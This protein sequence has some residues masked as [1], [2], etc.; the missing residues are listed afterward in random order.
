MHYQTNP[1][2]SGQ[3]FQYSYYDQGPQSQEIQHCFSGNEKPL[4]HNFFHHSSESVS[5]NFG[6]EPNSKLSYQMLEKNS[7]SKTSHH[8]AN[9]ANKLTNLE[10]IF[11]EE[12]DKNQSFVYL[13]PG[14]TNAQTNSDTNFH[15]KQSPTN[16]NEPTNVDLNATNSN[17]SSS[18]DELD[19]VSSDHFSNP[20]NGQQSE[21]TSKISN[22]CNVT[23][24]NSGT[25]IESN[26][27]LHSNYNFEREC[28]NC[29]TRSTPLWRRYG[30][31]NFLCNACG[32]YQRVN[33]NHRPLVRNIRRVTST[34]KR[35][36][37]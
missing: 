14:K 27:L 21:N 15:D 4:N 34:S 35:T 22:V 8:N 16:V 32:L 7:I 9:Y 37:K 12:N 31:N 11:S 20:Q 36:G 3:S 25:G 13:S 2:S 17:H 30:P 28:S 29:N 26:N 5:D 1:S 33:G 19:S 10:S 18:A 24:F 6:Y 23:S